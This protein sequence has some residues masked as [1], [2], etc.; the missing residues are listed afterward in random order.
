MGSPFDVS[1]SGTH[2]F[3]APPEVLW[4]ELQ[5]VD[6]FE[7]WWPWMKQVRLQ[8]EA[9]APLSIISFVVDPPVPYKMDIA[10]EVTASK[11]PEFL[12]GAV[13]GD[14]IGTAGLDFEPQGGR[15]SVAV[16]WDVELANRRMRAG[17]LVAR[18][19]L[20]WAQRW[21]VE[22]AL[23]GFRSHLDRLDD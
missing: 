3:E 20:L 18:P 15:T 6:M 13:S 5:R 14:L 2:L 19:I 7:R 23:R 17:I 22:V 21:A 12:Q 9:L 8:G 11:P 16:R 1:Y 4:H 10:V